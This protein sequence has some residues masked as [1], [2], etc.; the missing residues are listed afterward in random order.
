MIPF[1]IVNLNDFPFSQTTSIPF[2][3]RPISQGFFYVG[4]NTLRSDEYDSKFC[5]VKRQLLMT[6]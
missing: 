1:S 3:G 6:A 2:S 4:F 5:Q